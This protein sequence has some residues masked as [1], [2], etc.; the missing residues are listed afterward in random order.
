MYKDMLVC[1]ATKTACNSS[2]LV[3]MRKCLLDVYY[4]WS[5]KGR[6]EERLEWYRWY[7]LPGCRA[8]RR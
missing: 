8:F 7:E 2:Q 1:R 5:D 3:G 4:V 6:S